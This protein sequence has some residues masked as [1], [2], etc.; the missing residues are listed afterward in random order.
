MVPGGVNFSVFSRG[1]PAW[2][3]CSSIG[4]DDGRPARVI[5]ID[6]AANRTYHYWHVFVP[7]V[8]PGQIYGIGSTGRSI[9]RSGMRFDPTKV[10]LDPV[11]PRRC[12]SEELQPR[13]ASTRRRQHRD[14][15]EE[16]GGGSARR[17]IG[18]ATRR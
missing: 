18:K 12:G 14:G 13:A 10:L 8:Q 17:T 15:D 1:A 4:E 6:P 2:S 11:R 9:R 16:R 3:C 5:R 7:G